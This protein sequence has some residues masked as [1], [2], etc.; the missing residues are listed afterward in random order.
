[1]AQ[2]RTDTVLEI[3]DGKGKLSLAAPFTVLATMFHPDNPGQRLK[4][5][6][7]LFAKALLEIE[8][9]MPR[10]LAIKASAAAVEIESV[11]AKAGESAYGVAVAG[12]ILLFV[13]NA[14]LYSPEH[15]CPY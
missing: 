15:A 11:L 9:P 10:K 1:M 14:A 7:V 4:F 8:A 12:D 3:T 2:A 13:I 5:S 6:E